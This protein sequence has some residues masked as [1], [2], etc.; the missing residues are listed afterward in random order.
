MWKAG[1]RIPNFTAKCTN[2]TELNSEKLKG[3]WTVLF[4]YPKAFTPGCTK[5]VC[6]LRDGFEILSKFDVNVYGIS[7]DDIE[8]QMRFKEKYK[9]PY[10]LIADQKGEVIKS[11]GVSGL[12]GFAK[13]VTFIIDPDGKIAKVIGKVKVSKHYAQIAKVLENILG[14]KPQNQNNG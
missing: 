13:R 7:K 9:L 10:D 8:T 2:G 1:N 6:A 14:Q 12:F 4:F 11:F 5:E 3:K